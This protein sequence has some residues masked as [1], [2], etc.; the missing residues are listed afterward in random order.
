MAMCKPLD[1]GWCIAFIVYLI[2]CGGIVAYGIWKGDPRRLTHG[3]D[4]YGRLCGVDAGV[5]KTPYLYYCG[6]KYS[7]S[8]FPRQIDLESPS[9]VD[10]CPN[11]TAEYIP[12]IMPMETKT[13]PSMGPGQMSATNPKADVIETIQEVS[14]QSIASVSAYPSRPIGGLYCIPDF[15]N[16][17]LEEEV[18][19]GP[20]GGMHQILTAIGSFRRG[21]PVLLGACLLAIILSFV[22]IRCLTSATSDP[23]KRIE[24]VKRVLFMFMG[25]AII[26]LALLGAFFLFAPSVVPMDGC[27]DTMDCFKWQYQSRNPLYNQYA[28][29]DA[30]AYSIIVGVALVGAAF[31]VFCILVCSVLCHLKEGRGCKDTLTLVALSCECISSV[32]CLRLQPVVES[33]QK[34]VLGV[35]IM[36][37]FTFLITAGEVDKTAMNLNGKQVRG[38]YREFEY[39]PIVPIFAVFYI[40]GGI[41]LLEV[42]ACFGQYVTSFWA[43]HWLYPPGA[44]QWTTPQDPRP[45][46]NCLAGIKTLAISLGSL[47]K[48]AFLIILCRP[49]HVTLG[50]LAKG[51]ADHGAALAIQKA[52]TC[53]MAP[54]T[55]WI[56]QNSQTA[57]IVIALQSMAFSPAAV[58]Y[59]NTMHRAGSHPGSIHDLSGRAFILSVA[60]ITGISVT[61][62]SLAFIVLTNLSLFTDPTSAWVVE[63]PQF[64]SLVVFLLSA[65]IAHTFMVVFDHC[66]DALIFGFEHYRFQDHDHVKNWCPKTLKDL[67]QYQDGTALPADGNVSK[68]GPINAMF[69]RA[70]NSRAM[71]TE[72]ERLIG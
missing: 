20:L 71:G 51:H 53:C 14:V 32:C 8:G 65:Y 10:R 36:I 37:G 28:P 64:I 35:V 59:M 7:A 13:I 42:C 55:K 70:T 72:H 57:Y 68:R 3:I 23:A 9:C 48:G 15:K 26:F 5:E 44:D 47:A 21:W 67:C 69:S 66:G 38:L 1:G 4:Y 12:C 16:T 50:Y 43:V 30:L 41:W 62:S 31:I 34:L 33:F 29:D 25:P 18:A 22:Y 56:Q 54:Y 49:F 52:C 24:K 11:T 19:H 58:E 17:T 6:S 45:V 27:D 39:E 61:C 46:P 63:S 2:G 60:G 40:F